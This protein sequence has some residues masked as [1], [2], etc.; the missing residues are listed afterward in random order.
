MKTLKTIWDMLPL[1][2]W[3]GIIAGVIYGIWV[4]IYF[5]VKDQDIYETSFPLGWIILAFASFPRF[6]HVIIVETLLDWVPYHAN[7]ETIRDA[8]YQYGGYIVSGIVFV[9][10]GV[11]VG[12]T[13]TDPQRD[14]IRR[15]V[16]MVL[17]GVAVLMWACYAC[18]LAFFSN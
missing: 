11:I 17:L 15:R 4:R 3:T 8:V 7:W 1:Q 13:S 2:Y 10:I 5:Y 12:K 16:I 18:T 9:L 14:V 6:L